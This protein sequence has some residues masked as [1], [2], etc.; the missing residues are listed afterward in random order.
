MDLFDISES[1][2]LFLKNVYISDCVNR[3][4]LDEIFDSAS[5]SSDEFDEIEDDLP[6]L[7]DDPAVNNLRR[8]IYDIEH[9]KSLMGETCREEDI[10]RVY[11]TS[12]I[13][14]EKIP[15]YFYDVKNW[16]QFTR[17]KCWSCDRNF[18]SHPWFIPLGYTKILI[19]EEGE[20]FEKLAMIVHGNFCTC[21]CAVWWIKYVRDPA[22]GKSK[23]EMDDKIRLLQE[24]HQKFENEYVSYIPEAPWKTKMIQFGGDTTSAE[25]SIK[26]ESI[27]KY[28]GKD[29]V[30]DFII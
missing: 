30:G 26:I 9:V 4:E 8:S 16:P 6:E 22:I 19:D 20:K 14:P 27:N 3:E 2:I 13:I 11:N 12:M 29:L 7:D 18:N 5:S 24:L 1:N 10:M 23:T 21:N 17:I 25:F 28:R 15:R